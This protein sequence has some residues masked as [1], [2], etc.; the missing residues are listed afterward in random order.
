MRSRLQVDAL[1]T[2][3]RHARGANG[4][5][6]RQLAAGRRAARAWSLLGP[7][8]D[9]PGSAVSQLQL[10]CGIWQAVVQG[11]MSSS[12]H[13]RA[14]RRTHA[15]P[16]R[17]SGPGPLHPG[18]PPALRPPP[19]GPAAG[20]PL[21]GWSEPPPGTGQPPTGPPRQGRRRAAAARAAAAAVGCWRRKPCCALGTI[22]GKLARCAARSGALG[23]PAGWCWESAGLP[24]ARVGPAAPPSHLQR[25]PIVVW[26]ANSGWGGHWG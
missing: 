1:P 17:C 16:P 9:A 7:I 19:R 6:G 4:A 14:C 23:R 8:A 2:L 22:S 24:T 11:G 10:G 13:S 3:L 18:M 20:R 25:C 21:S 15:A 5:G 12:S 26:R